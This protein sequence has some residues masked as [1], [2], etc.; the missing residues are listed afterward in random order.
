MTGKDYVMLEED[1]RQFLVHKMLH[2]LD[3]KFNTKCYKRLYVGSTHLSYSQ[4]N[5]DAR[6]IWSFR[7]WLFAR[8]GFDPKTIETRRH[9]TVNGLFL[10]DKSTVF[11][12]CRKLPGW[13]I[14]V[15]NKVHIWY[16]IVFENLD[17]GDFAAQYHKGNVL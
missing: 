12:P 13:G 3:T 14:D 6:A 15:S 8:L 1:D 2:L 4:G 7:N 11:I 9:P 16:V 5:Q 17:F 10:K